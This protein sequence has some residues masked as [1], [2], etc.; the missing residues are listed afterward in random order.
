M[1]SIDVEKAKEIETRMYKARKMLEGGISAEAEQHSAQPVSLIRE[2]S[3][4]TPAGST[5]SGNEEQ[6]SQKKD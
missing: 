4:V 1:R 6:R 5:L 2:S 3:S